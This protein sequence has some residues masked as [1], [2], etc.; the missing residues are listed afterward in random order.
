[1]VVL[2]Q[3]GIDARL[4]PIAR[5]RRHPVVR[6][7]LWLERRGGVEA[8]DGVDAA[9]EHR[10]V[11][12][13]EVAVVGEREQVFLSDECGGLRERLA[14]FIHVGRRT[15]VLA[16]HVGERLLRCTRRSQPR[17]LGAR[18]GEIMFSYGQQLGRGLAGV[19]VEPAFLAVVL[20]TQ[21][22]V[23]GLLGQ[24]LARWSLNSRSDFSAGA[25]AAL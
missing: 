14:H 15:R 13:G 25:A 20:R 5:D 12:D 7:Q 21:P 11:D 6:P 2:A 24:R 16:R 23:A 1:V 19:Q 9:H 17:N 4:R 22:P 8:A 18:R 10:R 3:L